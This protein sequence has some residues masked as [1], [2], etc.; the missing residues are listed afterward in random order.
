[1]RPRPCECTAPSFPPRPP[2]PIMVM[3]VT[4]GAFHVRQSH[5]YLAFMVINIAPRASFDNTQEAQFFDTRHGNVHRTY[6]SE[7]GRVHKNLWQRQR[8]Y[9]V[10]R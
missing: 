10:D 6:S 3:N 4:G 5:I 8:L 9:F 2:F 1:M 7:A